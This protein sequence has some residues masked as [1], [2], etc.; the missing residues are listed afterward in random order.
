MLGWV[1]RYFQHSFQS[2]L[3][4]E[5]RINDFY[6]NDVT[7]DVSPVGGSF[8]DDGSVASYVSYPG[9]VRISIGRKTARAI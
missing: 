6:R 1:L 5:G 8:N 7:A 4:W 9:T 3:P 2:P